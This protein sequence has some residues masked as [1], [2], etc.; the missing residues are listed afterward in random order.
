MAA[1]LPASERKQ[2]IAETALRILA[3]EGARHLT[4]RHIGEALHMSD[5]GVF[6]HF[7]D[8]T[9]IL[10]AAIARFEEML[11]DTPPPR[12]LPPLERLRFFF[13]RRL[14]R[15][16]AH[17]EVLGLAFNDRL[18]EVA[19]EHGARHVHRVMKRSVATVRGAVRD[20]QREGSLPD[21]V[22]T[23][24][25]VWMFQ[26]VMRGAA[27][28]PVARRAAQSPDSIFDDLLVALGDREHTS[29]PK[30]KAR[31]GSACRSKGKKS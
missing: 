23:E 28:A 30:R 15:V 22:P 27:R 17:P 21:E 8:K 9:A 29:A 18:V 16:R 19:G 5:A 2:Q 24:V 20:A 6:R 1:R 25:L 10:E 26:G 14:A 11:E 4:A 31:T 7:A 12:S 13:T 3:S